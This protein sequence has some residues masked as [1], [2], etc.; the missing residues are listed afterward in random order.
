MSRRTISA[1]LKKKIAVEAIKE[2][3]TINEIASEY[4][5]H[6]VQVSK[7]KKELLEGA[8]LIFQK[9]RTRKNER[10]EKEEREAT[11]EQKI[12]KLSIEND[13]LKKKLGV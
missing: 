10:R 5:V 4:Q 12:G 9:D 7:W 6:P 11:L 1:E 8:I 3:R 2:Q 13:W